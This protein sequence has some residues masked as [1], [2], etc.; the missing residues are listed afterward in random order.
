MRGKFF[1]IN[2]FTLRFVWI[3][4]STLSF[5]NVFNLSFMNVYDCSTQCCLTG[6]HFWR[7]MYGLS[8][9]I[10]Q[11]SER[12]FLNNLNNRCKFEQSH[13]CSFISK[14]SELC[15]THCTWFFLNDYISCFSKNIPAAKRELSKLNKYS[16]P[17]GKLFC[18]KRVVN[19]LTKPPKQSFI[20]SNSGE[21]R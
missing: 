1:W 9:G 14:C 11:M 5:K 7:H 18:V 3:F 4:A 13:L 19:A 21:N 15:I 8:H 2:K 6:M 17:L 16:T 20:N 12:C 10:L